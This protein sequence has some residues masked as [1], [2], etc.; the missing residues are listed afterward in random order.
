MSLDL[1]F[2]DAQQAIADTL[3]QFCADRV[4][5][6]ALKAAG[7]A[8]PRALWQG[9][10]ELGVLA[11]GT[12][13][14]EGGAAE[15]VAASESLGAAAFPGPLA[16][17]ALAGALLAPKE[18]AALAGGALIVSAGRP[19]LLP[20]APLADLFLLVEGDRVWRAA[21][22]GEVEALETLGGEPWGHVE[23][24]RGEELGPAA[25]ALALHDLVLAAYLAGAAGRLVQETAEHARTR[26]QF[27]RAIGEFQAVA[28]P[29]ADCAMAIDASRTLARAA[30]CALDEDAPGARALAAAA[31]LSA[32]RSALDAAH[33]AHQLFGAV[34]ITLE[35]PVFARSRRIRQ[36]ASQPPSDAAG[37]EALLT[38]WGL[39]G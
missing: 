38:A 36:L 31:R 35:G 6:E 28:H 1:S 15:W 22:R 29:L 5:A 30:A 10:A 33:T 8:F 32:R 18:R 13:E 3:A 21:P 4:D 34:S 16:A 20:W 2:D 11:L 17:T 37:R 9:L 25:R 14:G 26:R 24:D 27:G 7:G 12:E 39:P 23:L 19:P